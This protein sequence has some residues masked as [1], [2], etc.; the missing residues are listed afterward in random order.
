VGGLPGDCPT[1]VKPDGPCR[2][3]GMGLLAALRVRHV[4]SPLTLPTDPDPTVEF[5]QVDVSGE[6]QQACCY[7]VFASP[8]GAGEP[9]TGDHSGAFGADVVAALRHPA[10]VIDQRF[11]FGPSGGEEGFAVEF[12]GEGLIFG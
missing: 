2:P 5:V 11:E 4:Y 7:E 6:H 12:G 3:A 10:E 8:C 1:L 9:A